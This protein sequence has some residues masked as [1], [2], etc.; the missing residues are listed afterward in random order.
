MRIDNDPVHWVCSGSTSGNTQS[1]ASERVGHEL[2]HSSQI[3]HA[4]MTTNRV[5]PTGWST[6]HWVMQAMSVWS[7]LARQR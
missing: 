3:T 4:A 6:L 1:Q 2:G 5:T 7:H